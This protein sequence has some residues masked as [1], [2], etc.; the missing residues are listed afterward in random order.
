MFCSTND[1]RIDLT[2]VIGTFR[3][4]EGLSVIISRELADQFDLPYSTVLSWITLRVHSS[5][6]SVGLTAAFSKVLAENGI[7]CNV[8]AALNHDHLFVPAKDS[9]R[10][11]SILKKLSE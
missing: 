8:V 1:P 6:E 7:S 4:T 9:E 3:E 10:A 2:D 5:L 11:L